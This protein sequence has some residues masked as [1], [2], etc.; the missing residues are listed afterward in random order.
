M[1]KLISRN[2][3]SILIVASL[4]TAGVLGTTAFAASVGGGT[5]NYGIGITGT[6]GYSDYYHAKNTHS[7]S[8][9][10][11]G[12]VVRVTNVA[13]KWVQASITKIPPTGLSYYWSNN[14]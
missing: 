9:A 2:I 11:N 1:T 4:F 14:S 7:S 13:G 10:N 6:F 5:W 8:V 12:K 3:K